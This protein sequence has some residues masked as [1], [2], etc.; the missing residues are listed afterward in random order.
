MDLNGLKYSNASQRI[1]DLKNRID[2]SLRKGKKNS[3]D[4]AKL[5]AIANS[6]RNRGNS[7]SDALGY[8]RADLSNKETT[9]GH[10]SSLSQFK[11]AI[12]VTG[13]EKAVNLNYMQRRRGIFED[14]ERMRVIKSKETSPLMRKIR[15]EEEEEERLTDIIGI[16]VLSQATMM[17]EKDGLIG[18]STSYMRQLKQFCNEALDYLNTRNV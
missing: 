6:I 5:S 2:Y 13:R 8:H 17:V 1:G 4:D 16:G 11:N 3:L 10:Y 9:L 14:G 7:N 12:G 18:L 15:K